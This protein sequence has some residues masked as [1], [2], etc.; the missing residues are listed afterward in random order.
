MSFWVFTQHRHSVSHIASKYKIPMKEEVNN[1]AGSLDI[2]AGIYS[3]SA[4]PTAHP[5]GV[6]PKHIHQEQ[7][8]IDI[9]RGIERYTKEFL[10]IP[11]DWVVEYNQLSYS[12]KLYREGGDKKWE[13]S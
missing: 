5:K 6:L 2:T 11:M 9:S 8:M 7:R 3:S 4:V 10:P 13:N 1:V 12:L